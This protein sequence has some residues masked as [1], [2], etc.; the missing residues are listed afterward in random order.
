M[1]DQT[2]HLPANDVVLEAIIYQA[3]K[4]A[5][6][7]AKADRRAPGICDTKQVILGAVYRKLQAVEDAWMGDLAER[8]E[9]FADMAAMN[10]TVQP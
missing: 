4:L 5:A 8:D 3:K 6:L 2:D 10:K 1:S 9:Y 7:Y